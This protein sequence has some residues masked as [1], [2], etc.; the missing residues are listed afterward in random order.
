MST[1]NY[2]SYTVVKADQTLNATGDAVLTSL[3]GINWTSFNLN[4]AG[5]ATSSNVYPAR[6]GGTG[7]TGGT[8]SYNGLIEFWAEPG[9]YKVTIIDPSSRIGSKDI[10]WSSVSGQDGG[11][12]GT[13]ISNDD[14][15]VSN[16]IQDGTIATADIGDSQI[17]NAKLSSTAVTSSKIVDGT[18]A[19]ADIGD[20]QITNA[21]LADEVSRQLIPIGA[22]IDWWRPNSSVSVPSGFVVCSGGTISSANHDFGTGASINVPDLRNKFILGASTA[23]TEGV[24]ATAGAAG[25]SEADPTN[26]PGIS[27]K[28]GS[29]GVRDLTHTHTTYAHN[30]TLATATGRAVFTDSIYSFSGTPANYTHQHT[31]YEPSVGEATDRS[32]MYRVKSSSSYIQ[33]GFVQTTNI[34]DNSGGGTSYNGYR[35]DMGTTDYT[36]NATQ[37][38][39]PAGS[40]AVASGGNGSIS[41]KAGLADASVSSRSGDGDLSTSAATGNITAVLDFRPSYYGLLKIMKVKRS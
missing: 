35:V 30:H 40:I 27:G 28:G 8:T 32:I 16:Q 7:V 11:I 34:A 1:R 9:E 4:A 39:T 17:T 36:N 14:A 37:T 10:F 6:S 22:V 41:G 29:N 26:A 2:F 13:K 38:I 31:M 15:L 24:A 33:T 21:K 5:A 19:T 23:T 3:A 20:S 18:I 12:P 25:A